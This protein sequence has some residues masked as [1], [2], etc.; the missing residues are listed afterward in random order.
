MTQTKEKLQLAEI[1]RVLSL[2][3]AIVEEVCNT[4]D[5]WHVK[6]VGEEIDVKTINEL[7]RKIRGD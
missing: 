1:N 6:H 4:I 2:G 3:D 5:N 7:K